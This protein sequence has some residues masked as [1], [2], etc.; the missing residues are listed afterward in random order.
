MERLEA[1]EEIRAVNITSAPYMSK[2]DRQRYTARLMKQAGVKRQMN[3]A[4]APAI[5]GTMGIGFNVQRKKT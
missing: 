4:L 2:D 3:P 5:F 1:E